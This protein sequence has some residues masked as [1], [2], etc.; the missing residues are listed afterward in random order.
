[1]TDRI[2]TLDPSETAGEPAAPEPVAE[3]H[4]PL[5]TPYATDDLV[6]GRPVEDRGFEAVETSLGLIAG[7]A[8][9]AVVA[10]PVGA[11]VGGVAGAAGGVA[12]GEMFERH[13]GRA[14]R[15][16]DATEGED[17]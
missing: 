12:A 4:V 10:G 17:A 16:L 9:G 13:E 8:I 5:A 15:M 3:P 14:A 7:V 1:M 2:A 6:A 11:I